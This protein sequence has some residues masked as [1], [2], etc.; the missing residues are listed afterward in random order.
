LA[1][2]LL[3]SVP[4]VAEVAALAVGDAVELLVGVDARELSPRIDSDERFS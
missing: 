3:R 2:N 4:E 1:R